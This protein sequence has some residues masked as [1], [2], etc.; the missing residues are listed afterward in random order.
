MNT[1]RYSHIKEFWTVTT[2]RGPRAYYYSTL[3]GRALP[4]PYAIAELLEATGQAT[5]TE[6]PIFVGRS[7]GW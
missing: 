1:D 7:R 4:V 2:K 5:R 6:K 3:A